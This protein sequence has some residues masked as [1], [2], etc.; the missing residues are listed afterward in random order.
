MEYV[1]MIINAC[2]SILSIHID[3]FGYSISLMQ[4]IVY[5]FV[6]SCLLFILNK[7]LN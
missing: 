4:F 6:V 1:K 5:C 3:L 2:S 7:A